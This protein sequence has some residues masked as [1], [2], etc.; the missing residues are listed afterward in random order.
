MTDKQIE[1][2]FEQLDY[3]T[4]IDSQI[5]ITTS[6]VDDECQ[7]SDLYSNRLKT[8]IKMITDAEQDYITEMKKIQDYVH[9]KIDHINDR[10]K[11]YEK[12]KPKKQASS[13]IQN[14]EKFISIFYG[15]VNAIQAE[16]IEQKSIGERQIQK[17]VYPISEELLNFFEA[18]KSEIKV[19][20]ETGPVLNMNEFSQEIK[21]VVAKNKKKFKK[22][23]G[24][25]NSEI[26]ESVSLFEK[27][28]KDM[29]QTCDETFKTVCSNYASYRVIKQDLHIQLLESLAK[30]YQPE[31]VL[32]NKKDLLTL[33]KSLDL[34]GETDLLLN[35]L[36]IGNSNQWVGSPNSKKVIDTAS[37]NNPSLSQ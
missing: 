37:R 29:H 5:K 4:R 9:V 18:K 24:G 8:I 22:N 36:S 23:D 10:R 28:M 33:G 21:D 26:A 30:I 13:I 2:S 16:V 11:S 7:Q 1:K 6:W 32:K 19:H 25:C 27:K 31:S 3:R 20:I 14:D 35:Q 15:K 34:Q 12:S 17:Q